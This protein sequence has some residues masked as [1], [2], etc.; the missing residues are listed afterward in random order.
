MTKIEIECPDLT[1]LV[2]N[3]SEVDV[4]KA[5]QLM[6]ERVGFQLERGT[7]PFVPVRTGYLRS[8][9][10]VWEIGNLF[11]TVESRTNYAPYVHK[12]KPYF[13][14]GINAS[15]NDLQSIVSDMAN[16]IINKITKK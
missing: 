10:R 5:L 13:E 16:D 2:K 1:K 8:Q 7:K 9:T 12:R 11:T 6:V 15:K 4:V 3:I 14:W